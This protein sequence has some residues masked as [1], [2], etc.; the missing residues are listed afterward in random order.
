MDYL[1]GRR[2]KTLPWVKDWSDPQD[3]IR[4]EKNVNKLNWYDWFWCHPTSFN[5]IYYGTNCLGIILFTI[6]LILFIYSGLYILAA[7]DGIIIA[8]LIKNL[9]GKIK[10]YRYSKHMTFYDIYLRDWPIPGDKVK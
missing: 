6:P 3:H 9:I 7:I 4:F 1:K 2:D 5:L 10:K 8:L